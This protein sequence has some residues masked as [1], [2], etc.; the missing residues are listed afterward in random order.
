MGNSL[1]HGAL[2]LIRGSL[3]SVDRGRMYIGGTTLA[4][5]A[6]GSPFSMVSLFEIIMAVILGGLSWP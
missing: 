3:I 5:R 4:I 6:V 2:V 1:G